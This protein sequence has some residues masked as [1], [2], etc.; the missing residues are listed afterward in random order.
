[1]ANKII[2]SIKKW[3][4][5]ILGVILILVASVFGGHYLFTPPEATGIHGGWNQ[6][7]NLAINASQYQI[8]QYNLSGTSCYGDRQSTRLYLDNNLYPFE[9]KQSGNNVTTD[10]LE[11]IY[12]LSGFSTRYSLECN[13]TGVDWGNSTV[14]LFKDDFD[15]TDVDANKWITLGI[16]SREEKDGWLYGTGINNDWTDFLNS[17]TILTRSTEG[18]FV[19][20]EVNTSYYAGEAF[21]LQKADFYGVTGLKTQI[22]NLIGLSYIGTSLDNYSYPPLVGQYWSGDYLGNCP[23][24]VYG[25]VLNGSNYNTGGTF[26][27]NDTCNRSAS[28]TEVNMPLDQNVASADE[29]AIFMVWKKTTSASQYNYVYASNYKFNTTLPPKVDAVNTYSWQQNYDLTIN[30]SANQILQYNFTGTSCY[31]DRQSTRLYLNGYLYPF[32]WKQAGNNVTTDTMEFIYNLSGHSTGSYT[33]KCNSSIPIEWGNQTV[34]LFK[35]DFNDANLDT[36]KWVKYT[37]GGDFVEHDGLVYC[38]GNGGDNANWLNSTTTFSRGDTGVYLSIGQNSSLSP[39]VDEFFG[40]ARNMHNDD[41]NNPWY[42]Y[43]FYRSNGYYHGLIRIGGDGF[44]NYPNAMGGNKMVVG[45]KLNKSSENGVVWMINDTAGYGGGTVMTSYTGT[46]DDY[47]GMAVFFYG[48]STTPYSM[49]D[50][51]YVSNYEFNITLP[52]V[53]DAVYTSNLPVLQLNSPVNAQYNLTSNLDTYASIP[54]LYDVSG[55]TN[56]SYINISGTETIILPGCTNSTII[57]PIGNWNITLHA[58]NA[59]GTISAY[60]QFTVS[61][62]IAVETAIGSNMYTIQWRVPFLTQTYAYGVQPTNQTPLNGTW[63]TRNVGNISAKTYLAYN[64]TYAGVITECAGNFRF[65]NSTLLSTNYQLIVNRDIRPIQAYWC[66]ATMPPEAPCYWTSD[67]NWSTYGVGNQT[68]A[69][70]YQ[71]YSGLNMTSPTWTAKVS[72]YNK[73]AESDCW[74]YTDSTWVQIYSN[75]TTLLGP[76]T[77]ISTIPVNCT[78]NPV[79]QFKTR[80]SSG[81]WIG[82]YVEYY[83]GEL[84]SALPDPY[85]SAPSESKQIWCQRNYTIVPDKKAI[86][87]MFNF[88]T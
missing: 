39:W 62:L 51:V 72:S 67:Y 19:T 44:A 5:H 11:F 54:L 83:E 57:A 81:G 40:L 59:A 45:I 36:N 6:D 53:A 58:T 15:D 73:N 55:A 49:Y 82:E 64:D 20:F 75:D 86:G 69:W 1:M 34:F 46:Y 60:A 9:W 2:D 84:E 22:F 65:Y 7:Y 70:V 87:W 4:K 23:R 13:A 41:I 35:D 47:D 88:T 66:N 43:V 21:G 27:S 52:P 68:D 29:V 26:Y 10:T 61:Q 71:N 42:G 56:C 17:T 25:F 74:D 77:L 12:N 31:T 8:L 16:G 37:N 48:K 63:R 14:F 33:L 32:E 38:I 85:S 3:W 78:N 30:A 50:Y 79:I 18:L 76:T 80:T 24:A 28:Y